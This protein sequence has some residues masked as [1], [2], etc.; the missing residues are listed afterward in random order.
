MRSYLDEAKTVLDKTGFYTLQ[1]V[2]DCIAAGTMQSFG[3]GDTWVVTQIHAFP[4]KKV[5]EIFL[6]IG[7]LADAQALEPEVEAFA[8]AQGVSSL[9]TWGTRDGWGRIRTKGWEDLGHVFERKL[10]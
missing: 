3:K 4:R 1:D 6:V 2:L 7:D 9:T 8:R 10:A 5:L